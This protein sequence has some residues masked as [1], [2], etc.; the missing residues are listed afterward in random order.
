MGHEM[1]DLFKRNFPFIIRE[2]KTVIKILSDPNN[3]IYEKYNEEGKLIGISVINKNTIYLMCVDKPYRSQGI[4]TEL[5]RKSENYVLENGYDNIRIGAGEEYIMPGIPTNIKPFKQ[6]L[7]T[8]NIFHE[9]NNE[10]CSFF[11][12]RG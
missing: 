5:L 8:E 1:F 12:K 11:E 4:G 7:N 9:V 6:K 10:A 2:D 3:K